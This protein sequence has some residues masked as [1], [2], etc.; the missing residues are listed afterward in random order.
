MRD[1]V[2]GDQATLVEHAGSLRL[3]EAG[4]GP[5]DD[6]WAT[7]MASAMRTPSMEMRTRMVRIPL[8][9]GGPS[10]QGG[11][12][13][14]NNRNSSNYYCYSWI[15]ARTGVAAVITAIPVVAEAASTSLSRRPNQEWQ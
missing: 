1:D 10:W 3:I 12:S 13:C 15:A 9:C 4:L 6:P 7:D 8:Y 11:G 5:G 14:C 2:L